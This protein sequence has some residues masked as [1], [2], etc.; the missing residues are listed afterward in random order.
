MPSLLASASAPW[1]SGATLLG[2]ML[3]APWQNGASLL[4][5]GGTYTPG[6]PP[7]GGTPVTPGVGAARFRLAPAARYVAVADWQ[8]VDV[9]DASVLPAERV[10][11]AT[12]RDSAFW[13]IRAEGLPLAAYAQLLQGEQPARVRLTAGW[14]TWEFI[15][16]VVSRPRAF[17]QRSTSFT[18]R[19]PAALAAAPFEASQNWTNDG[20]SSAAQMATSVLLFCGVTVDWRIESW[21][22]PDRVF[23]VTGTPLQ[24]V[25]ALADAV[26]AIVASHPS[27]A[28][29]Q[30]LPGYPA[31]PNEWR[32]GGV[33][34]DIALDAVLSDALERVES[35]QYD[36]VY[37]G[38]QQGGLV[39]YVRIDG[40][41]GGRVAPFLTDPLL[42]DEPALRQRGQAILG[43]ATGGQVSVPL[44]LPVLHG[45]DQP[46]VL[47]LNQMV[48]VQDPGDVWYGLVRGVAATFEHGKAVQ[49]VTCERHLSLWE[50]SVAV[51]PEL[52]PLTF[53]GPIDD[54][55]LTVGVAFSL[56][57]AAE[58]T[59]GT[60]PLTWSIRSGTL[61]AGLTL[62]SATGVISGTPTTVQTMTGFALRCV[63]ADGGM[64]DSNSFEIAVE[65]AGGGAL[66]WSTTFPD[67]VGWHGRPLQTF[68]A[69]SYVTGGTPPYVLTFA[70]SAIPPALSFNSAPGPFIYYSGSIPVIDW[71]AT[72]VGNQMTWSGAQYLLD[73]YPSYK[74]RVTDAASNFV[75]SNVFSWIIQEPPGGGGPADP[76]PS[77]FRTDAS[78][79]VQ[80]GG[81]FN[82]GGLTVGTVD[83][84]VA[85]AGF[86]GGSAPTGVQ[87]CGGFFAQDGTS[88][89]ASFRVHTGSI[90]DPLTA[91]LSGDYFFSS[92]GLDGSAPSGKFLRGPTAFYP[93]CAVFDS[94]VVGFRLD[95]GV[96]SAA[97]YGRLNV[98]DRTGAPLGTFTNLEAD[99]E[100]ESFYLVTG[101]GSAT[102]A[103]FIFEVNTGDAAGA[104][105][106]L[107]AFT[108]TGLVA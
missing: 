66:T 51:D 63:D 105:V 13:T 24:A 38:G 32:T 68:N 10:S 94:D 33:D 9:R 49:Q 3:G 14:Q 47:A 106:G 77:V 81:T 25:R 72:T 54:Q 39:G 28:V 78:R 2:S 76:G 56:A 26:G 85:A 23:S 87:F 83:P 50:G 98:F 79:F 80:S 4:S 16:D 92:V 82:F 67:M 62:N 35:A 58:W 101:D 73:T 37:L 108:T 15:V 18:G 43:G 107:L 100:Y 42:T 27:E 91:D 1:Q 71:L 104:G 12:D 93:V 59:G 89:V 17:G 31:L 75:E 97:G 65:A 57:T 60:T 70:P 55:A 103:G 21:L 34:V 46:G 52:D 7:G 96:L 40:T 36:G 53:A 86:A 45:T 48:R 30:V 6:S 64:A 19:S 69:E 88:V 29:L 95:V 11:I 5:T 41:A 22:I 44:E 99:G 84:Y 74:L 90:S 20:D 102:I 8:L 61:P